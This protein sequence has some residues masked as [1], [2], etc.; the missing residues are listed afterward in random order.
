MRRESKL[1]EFQKIVRFLLPIANNHN[2]LLARLSE[3]IHFACISVCILGVLARASVLVITWS[4]M[5]NLETLRVANSETAMLMRTFVCLPPAT[6]STR[7]FFNAPVCH[8]IRPLR[9]AS[10]VG[11]LCV[12]P[13]HSIFSYTDPFAKP[14]LL[15]SV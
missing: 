15:F 5:I 8:C 7:P 11:P 12:T 6:P 9:Y 1:I 13:Y 3:G 2:D 10:S 4:K 14:T